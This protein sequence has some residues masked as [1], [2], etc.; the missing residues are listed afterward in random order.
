MTPTP[1]N[2]PNDN[3]QDLSILKDLPDNEVE[4]PHNEFDSDY[5]DE[6]TYDT[7]WDG[8]YEDDEEDYEDEDDILSSM[9]P[10]DEDFMWEE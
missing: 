6:D 10:N 5:R 7:D 3:P 4:Y 8:D 2:E 9:F 1:F